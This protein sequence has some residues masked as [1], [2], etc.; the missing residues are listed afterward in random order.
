[1]KKYEY[2]TKRLSSISGWFGGLSIDI[3]NELGNEG[4]EFVGIVSECI[5]KREIK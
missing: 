4:W 1:V 5:L 3:L 2:M